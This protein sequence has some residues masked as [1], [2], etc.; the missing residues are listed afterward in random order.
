MLN[1]PILPKQEKL[2]IMVDSRSFNELLAKGN[3]SAKAILNHSICKYFDFVRS[4]VDTSYPELNQVP[5]FI[6][7]YDSKGDLISIDVVDDGL[8]SMTVFGYRMQDVEEIGKREIYK[9]QSLSPKEK[10]SIL[11]IFVHSALHGLGEL[12]VL[13][14][15]NKTLLSNRR[16]FESHFPGRPLNIAT[17]EEAKEIMDLFAKYRG[18]Y[19][20]SSNFTV[21]KGGW[22]WHSFRSKIP[23]Y[24]VGDSILE[25][26]ASRF[27]HLLMSIDEIGFQYYSGANNDTM[28]AMIYHFNYFISLVSGIFD[29]LA[30]RTKNQLGIKF[31]GDS[32]DSRTSLNP[33]AGKDFLKA[34]R[35]RNPTLRQHITNY[36]HFIK[37]IYA[38][39]EVVI[40]REM[41]PKSVFM[42][43]DE[44]WKANFIDVD[45]TIMDLITKCDEKARVYKPITVWGVYSEIPGRHF[46]EP[47]H[48]SKAAATS[49]V[50]FC[51]NFLHLL[52][53]GDFIEA[54]K[55]KG[56][57]NVFVRTIQMMREESLGF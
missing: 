46:L 12:R 38:L 39:R 26:F 2:G 31:D 42:Q 6:Q 29:N 5:A 34:L 10:E 51:N 20:V 33:K 52:G 37:L 14:T 30:I 43:V 55:L 7:N 49:L 4:P 23:N 36:V 3:N 8:K 27:V 22:Y 47:Y 21:N 25:A 50:P 9:K 24:N 13:V 18:K 54:L 28:E 57:S 15:S 44:R 32:I 16:W 41:L 17:V 53:F 11:L 1:G 19:H 45:A 40:H 48:F 35:E 56:K